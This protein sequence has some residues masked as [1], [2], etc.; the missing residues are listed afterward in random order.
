MLCMHACHVYI[1]RCIYASR[2]HKTYTNACMYVCM[3][4]C[5]Y[6]CAHACI[7]ACVR[8][9]V[10]VREHACVCVH[11]TYVCT[12]VHIPTYI[13]TL[14]C[15]STRTRRHHTN[16][17]AHTQVPMLEFDT[18]KRATAAHMLTHPWLQVYMHCSVAHSGL[19]V[20]SMSVCLFLCVCMDE[21]VHVWIRTCICIHVHIMEHA[22]IFFTSK[23]HISCAP[24]KT[25]VQA[26]RGE[27]CKL[28]RSGAGQAKRDYNGREQRNSGAAPGRNSQAAL[29]RYSAPASR[30]RLGGFGDPAAAGGCRTGA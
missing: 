8:V 22:D 27:H 24:L 25:G 4:F 5:M 16:T 28:T 26:T 9:C 29:G 2:L 15:I 30:R 19:L 23:I 14:A 20:L 17:H 3:H 11:M 21:F 7:F 18:T 12:H 13:Y 1:V 10:L 6:V